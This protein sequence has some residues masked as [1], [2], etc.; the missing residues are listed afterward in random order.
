MVRQVALNTRKRDGIKLRIE[1]MIDQH[2][3]ELLV[4]PSEYE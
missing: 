1:V 4:S 2:V 3:I